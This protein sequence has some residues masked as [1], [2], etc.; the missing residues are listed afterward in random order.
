MPKNLL[1]VESPAKAKTIEK[2]LGKDYKVSSS[3]GHIR[4]LP[5]KNMGIDT[6][7][8]F[9]PKYEISKDKQKVVKA[10]KDEVKK[11]ETV[12]LATDEDREGEAIS[13]HLC[14]VLGLDVESTKRIV[15]HEITKSAIQGA[16]T[17]PRTVNMNI[18]NAQQARRVLDR[19]VGFELSELLWRKVK[20][21]LSAGRVQSV[22]VK[23]IVER[24]REIRNFKAQSS[25][26]VIGFFL[27]AD[28]KGKKVE[29]KA[30]LDQ[31]FT[32]EEEAMNFLKKINGA[33]YTIGDIKVK[34]V[35][36]NPAPPFITSTL[37][38]EASRKYG[39]S[40]KRTMMAAQRLY[41]SGAI[42]YM[43]TDSTA[44]SK[45]ALSTIN[46][47]IKDQFGDEYA[48]VRQFK[49]KNASAQE[50]HEAIRPT[51]IDR[52]SAGKDSDQMRIYELIWK[53]TIAS[54]MA[55]AELE[56]TEV[57]IEISS[58]SEAHFS[59]SGEVMKFDGFLKVYMESKD[60]ENGENGNGIL[61]P[62]KLGQELFEEKIE[63]VQ[64]FSK[65]KPRY[66]EATLVKKLEALGIGRPSTYAP[67]IS[68]IMEEDRGYVVKSRLE[69]VER[70]Y[71]KLVLAAGKIEK[72]Q[73]S[74]ITGASSNR[75]VPTD[76][77]IIVSDFLEEHF[78]KVMDYSFT[79]EIEEKLDKIAEEGLE[80]SQ[81]IK[82]FYKPFHKEVEDTMENAERVRAK[83]V[84]G[85]DP[86]TGFT[87][88]VQLSKFGPVVQ[89]GTREEVGEE[90]KPQFAN[91]LPG[92]AMELITYEEAME[93]FKLPRELGDYE[94]ENIVVNSGRYGPYVKYKDL[95]V[96][97]PKGEDPLDITKKRA[98]ELV[99]MKQDE[100]K[101]IGQYKDHDI[102]KGKG[103]FG[104]YLKWNGLFVNV[105]KR[106]DFDQI[107]IEE[108]YELIDQKIEKE[109]NR[110]IKKWDDEKIA[111]ENGRW[112]PF[113]RFKKKS[114]KL[115]KKDGKALPKED[116]EKFTLDQVK[117]L[118]EEQLPGSF[119]AK[120]PQKTK[121]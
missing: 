31:E 9:Q 21:K 104:P 116:L 3:F 10:L 109:A 121:K 61:P 36:R 4:D 44:L 1:I 39:F 97:I 35:K 41:E 48:K 120:K 19:L 108:A 117:A 12:W 22:A 85:K 49:S 83:R 70:A 17:T 26:K 98:V 107:S 50:A 90:G 30:Y 45:M 79:A 32:S 118:I 28:D 62:L 99:K 86:K 55:S 102:T 29:L 16:I 115:P 54:Q 89:I 42:T 46:K 14:E 66:T 72:I 7:G 58:T 114:V 88:L 53:R 73:E 93:L 13:W 105:P 96:S 40:V 56:R 71:T 113:I 92:Q 59:A 100:N 94:G 25:F 15:F 34:P 101:P 74:E 81:M 11:V 68:R 60:D 103:R 119:K 82:D 2:F 87:V 5:K 112:G 76:L 63:S 95:F 43:R 106:I 8:S 27:V 75:L 80:W 52:H 110:Y 111:I 33:K 77:G 18:V 84:L 20:G 65:P 67:T 38:Q 37:Q 69:G 51:Y 47:E 64:K 24:E 6:D 57:S 23:L 78:S 91:M